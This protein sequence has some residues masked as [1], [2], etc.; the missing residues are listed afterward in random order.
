MQYHLKIQE[1]GGLVQQRLLRSHKCLLL[2][3]VTIVSDLNNSW[4]EYFR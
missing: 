1:S 4:A 2:Q 3:V